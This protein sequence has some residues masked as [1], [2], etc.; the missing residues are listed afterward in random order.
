M[1]E[2]GGLDQIDQDLPMITGNTSFQLCKAAY[3]SL[4]LSTVR[5]RAISKFCTNLTHLIDKI[6][7]RTIS[8]SV[9]RELAST[10]PV[11]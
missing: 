3:R 2:R 10:Q 5:R 8:S 11:G 4:K 7:E 6:L 1:C 9:V